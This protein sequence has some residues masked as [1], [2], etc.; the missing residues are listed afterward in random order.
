MLLGVFFSV[1]R[2]WFYYVMYTLFCVGYS[3]TSVIIVTSREFV[4]PDKAASAI[5]FMNLLANAGLAG[6]IAVSGWIMDAF[7]GSSVKVED[8]IIYPQTA[9]VWILV[10]LLLVS[11]PAVYFAAKTPETYGV[12]CFGKENGA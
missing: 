7:V 5:G 3:Q 6:I 12:N 9:Y 1:S 8:R 11:L 4:Q 2:P 10:V